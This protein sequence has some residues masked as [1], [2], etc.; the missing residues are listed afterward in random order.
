L[1]GQEY[2]DK[3][4]VTIIILFF[5]GSCEIRLSSTPRFVRWWRN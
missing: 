1:K 3:T 5:L 4:K 2:Y